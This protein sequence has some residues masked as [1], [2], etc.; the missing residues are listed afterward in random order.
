ME[1]AKS[2]TQSTHVEAMGISRRRALVGLSALACTSFVPAATHDSENDR[3]LKHTTL[4]ALAHGDL[5][6]VEAFSSAYVRARRIQI[7]VPR[8][9]TK[10]RLKTIYMLD[11]RNLFER[12]RSAFGDIW[13]AH[14]ILSSL[15][16]A[17]VVEPTLVVGVDHG[18]ERESEYAPEKAVSALRPELRKLLGT[19]QQ[20]FAAEMHLKFLTNEVRPFVEKHFNVSLAAHDTNIAGASMGGLAA[21]YSFCRAPHVFGGAACLSTHLPLAGTSPEYEAASATQKDEIAQAFIGWLAKNLP[22]PDR[23]RRIYFDHGTEGQLESRYG[24]YQKRVNAALEERGYRDPTHFMSRVYQ[25][26]DHSER[27]WRTRLHVPFKYL[28]ANRS[29][30]AECRVALRTFWR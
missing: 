14:S 18:V 2:T 23:R 1:Q 17:A 4:I 8:V 7:W 10:R 5:H 28:L 12:E 24:A 11:G 25:G 21:A 3:Q 13:D 27:A 19:N 29:S 15:M 30:R 26:A 20:V 16:S 9:A 22:T 6:T